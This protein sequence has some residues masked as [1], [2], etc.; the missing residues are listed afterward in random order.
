MGACLFP[1]ILHLK[2]ATWQYFEGLVDDRTVFAENKH[3]RFMKEFSFHDPY[4]KSKFYREA[5]EDADLEKLTKLI[6]ICAMLLQT[7]V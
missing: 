2:R 5:L 3:S 1:P 6:G 7:K 4:G